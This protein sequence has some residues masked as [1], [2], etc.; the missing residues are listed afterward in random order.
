MNCIH[1]TVVGATQKC[2]VVQL[3]Y[4]PT[5]NIETSVWYSCRQT[6]LHTPS[7]HH[8]HTH[9]QTQINVLGWCDSVTDFIEVTVPSGVDITVVRDGAC[10]EL[11]GNAT[12]ETYRDVLLSSRSV[13]L[14]FSL[15]PPL[16]LSLSLHMYICILHHWH[17]D[18]C[19][20]I[21]QYQSSV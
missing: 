13:C 5:V 7:T 10:I 17:I 12:I 15:F 6:F 20:V 8:S 4:R 2:A 14:S 3:Y 16:S 19:I 18:V 21:Y 11:I 9:A 1:F